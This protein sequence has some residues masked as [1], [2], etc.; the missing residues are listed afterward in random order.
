[1]GTSEPT[2]DANV[3]A[4]HRIAEEVFSCD[5]SSIDELLAEEVVMHTPVGDF[6]GR[7]AVRG[8]VE[9]SMEAV[10][11]M[12]TPIVEGFGSGDLVAGRFVMTGTQS[13]EARAMQLPATG[14]RVEIPGALFARFEDGRCVEIWSIWD[15]M[16]FLQQLGLFP[17]SPGTIARLTLG[18]LKRRLGLR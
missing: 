12:A 11:D 1:M 17:D 7:D 2:V 8:Y 5:L 10:P 3:E 14:R 9:D 16:E 15:K 18:Q 4:F 13:G 6:A